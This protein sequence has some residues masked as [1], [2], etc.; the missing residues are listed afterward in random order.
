MSHPPSLIASFRSGFSQK[1]QRDMWDMSEVMW[2]FS[3][4]VRLLSGQDLFLFQKLYEIVYKYEEALS[5]PIDYGRLFRERTML[6]SNKQ[7]LSMLGEDNL[8]DGEVKER[9]KDVFSGVKS[10][11]LAIARKLTIMS[12]MNPGFVGDE[13]LWRWLEEVLKEFT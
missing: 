6:P 2:H 5:D 7:L 4:L 9:E 3:R 10:D 12:E 13:S 1:S 8:P 11:R